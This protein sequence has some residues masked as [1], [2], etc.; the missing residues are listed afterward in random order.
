MEAKSHAGKGSDLFYKENKEVIDQMIAMN[1][2]PIG[3]IIDPTEADIEQTLH[4]MRVAIAE[5]A[6][7]ASEKASLLKSLAEAN[8]KVEQH[9]KEADSKQ[10]EIDKLKKEC[11]AI[12]TT[13]NVQREKKE[14][15]I[16]KVKNDNNELL[17]QTK[18]LQSKNIE[19]MHDIK[20]KE[21]D[22]SE[23]KEK[24]QKA[25][26]DKA[27]YKNSIEI[28]NSLNPKT[29]PDENDFSLVVCST[30]G[31]RMKFLEKENALLKES[32]ERFNKDIIDIYETK[33]KAIQI[34]D[35]AIQVTEQLNKLSP[36][37]LSNSFE[38][39]KD[40]IAQTLYSNTEALTK[41]SAKLDQALSQMTAIKPI[42]NEQV[43][44]FNEILMQVNQT[45]SQFKQLASAKEE[46]YESAQI[47][48]I[49]NVFML[50]NEEYASN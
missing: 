43:H 49:G 37:M 25:I 12:R 29:A 8:A 4:A 33:K 36:S 24:Y 31:A 46:K 10:K 48:S 15:E 45:I 27:P 11:D 35:P 40:S 1:M 20:K 44:S 3:T 21:L 22:I 26:G 2:E 18:Q 39:A 28:T 41:L 42:D 32:I 47:K 34:I 14:E 16:K 9:S 5:R 19:M 6:Q 17:R 50:S 13:N 30:L 38:K 23:L 7:C